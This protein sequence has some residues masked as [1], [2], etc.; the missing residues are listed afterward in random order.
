[1]DGHAHSRIN[2]LRG[3]CSE[4]GIVIAQGSRVGLEQIGRVLADPHAAVPTLIRGTMTLLV[5]EVR[6]LEVRIAQLERELTALAR[7]SPV[8]TTLLSIPGV[9]LPTATA[10]VAATSGQVSHF[11]DARHFASWFGL[12][13]KEY[14]SGSVR[15][16]GRIS[17]RGDRYLRM[18]LT[19]GARAVLRAATAARQAG[20]TIEPLRAWA[21]AVQA[22]SNHNKAACALA[23]KLACICYATLRDGE[24]Y[25]AA[26]LT[27]KMQRT[28]YALP[29]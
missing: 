27:K 21:L 18:L 6:L 15:Y 2:A 7:Q 8:C 25:A 11:R 22:R 13:P 28:A 14:S 20:R 5:E 16:L 10:M 23:N 1:M 19:H 29:A 24:P 12:T 9:G 17:K 3:F 4:F 26:R